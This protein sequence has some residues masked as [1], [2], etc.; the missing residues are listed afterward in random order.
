[1]ENPPL[2]QHYAG[3][4]L[5]LAATIIDSFLLFAVI[6]PVLFAIYGVDY[7][8]SDMRIQGIWDLLLQTLVP[9]LITVWFW[10]RYRG[11]PGKV[12]LKLAV[13]D[14]STGR[15]MTRGQAVGRYF[16]Y[17][18]S[19]LPLGLGFIWIAFD[20]KKRALHDLLCGTQVIEQSGPDRN[21]DEPTT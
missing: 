5:R 16:A 4:W 20:P 19:T 1:M 7:F 10:R 6:L 13:V 17:I 15:A 18:A 21:S 11:T 12:I 14:G 8:K 3:F 9:L 2:P